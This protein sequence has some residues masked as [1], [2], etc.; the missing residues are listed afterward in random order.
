MEDGNP[1]LMEDYSEVG[2]IHGQSPEF[3]PVF[4]GEFDEED[5][6]DNN[7]GTTV[8]RLRRPMAGL[9]LNLEG[10]GGDD[11]T[12]DSYSDNLS[13]EYNSMDEEVLLFY[14]LILCYM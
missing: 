10:G 9:N 2:I 3:E 8:R 5:E 14:L 7:V 11:D 1:F 6:E 4:E 12:T 13:S